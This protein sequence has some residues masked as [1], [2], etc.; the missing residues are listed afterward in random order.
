MAQG[1]ALSPAFTLRTRR[2]A[3]PKK[4]AGLSGDRDKY[5]EGVAKMMDMTAKLRTLQVRDRCPVCRSP[6]PMHLLRCAPEHCAVVRRGPVPLCAQD[7][8]AAMQPKLQER[9]AE[10]SQLMAMIQNEKAE[11]EAARAAI[12]P[13]EE[14][15]C[16]RGWC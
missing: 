10:A 5:L 14:Q 7:K 15:V 8:I 9:Q 12:L 1:R 2:R 4:R 11:A 3:L 13:E 16:M 6:R